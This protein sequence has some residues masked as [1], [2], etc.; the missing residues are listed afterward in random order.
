MNRIGLRSQHLLTLTAA[1]LGMTMPS[2]ASLANGEE[3]GAFLVSVFDCYMPVP[4]DFVLNSK[5]RSGTVLFLGEALEAMRIAI[6][7]YDSKMES[8]FTLLSK[9]P[10]DGLVVEEWRNHD[11]TDHRLTRIHDGKQ[12]VVVYGGTDLLIDSLVQ[13]C[14]TKKHGALYRK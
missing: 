8:D 10:E 4:N 12:Q 7:A 13:G 2:V 14:L 5:D 11:G 6:T 3:G 9:R 1:L